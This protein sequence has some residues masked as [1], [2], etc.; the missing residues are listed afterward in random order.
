MMTGKHAQMTGSSRRH[1]T[2]KIHLQSLWVGGENQ[3]AGGLLDVN[4]EGFSTPT[5]FF[6]TGK[7][8]VCDGKK[9]PYLIKIG[10][11]KAANDGITPSI[12]GNGVKS[13][14]SP[15][16]LP[17]ILQAAEHYAIFARPPTTPAKHLLLLLPHPSF[18]NM[19]DLAPYPEG[20]DICL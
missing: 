13:T 10:D 5:Q 6:G 17:Q 20:L 9:D 3:S 18:M 15:S 7:I 8:L 4:W 12:L 16:G 14:S 19:R 11:N 1:L 2:G